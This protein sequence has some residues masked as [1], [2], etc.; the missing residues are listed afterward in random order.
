MKL[1]SL[2]SFLLKWNW[3][4]YLIS[5]EVV[6]C[7]NSGKFLKN[8]FE[9]QR[10]FQWLFVR[11]T[12]ISDKKLN[13]WNFSD[14]LQMLKIFVNKN[15]KYKSTLYQRLFSV[16][17]CSDFLNFWKVPELPPW[18]HRVYFFSKNYKCTV[19]NKHAHCTGWIFFQKQ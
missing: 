9:N 5:R 16:T 12:K 13:I 2:L 15:G 17:F 6:G 19:S 1:D 7:R 14:F 18:L 8:F 4:I 10:L 3:M 11:S